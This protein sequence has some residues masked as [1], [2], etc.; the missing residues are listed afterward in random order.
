MR[1]RFVEI[2]E[3][4]VKA[5]VMIVFIVSPNIYNMNILGDILGQQNVII[6]VAKKNYPKNKAKRLI[7]KFGS[8]LLK[9][10]P[11]MYY[12]VKN[13]KIKD[14]IE[15]YFIIES[16]GLRTYEFT[17]FKNLNK[18]NN[19]HLMLLLLNSMSASSPNILAVKDDVLHSDWEAVF[20]FDKKDAIQYG[21]Q[22]IGLTYFSTPQKIEASP[23][24]SDAYFIG[25]LKGNREDLIIKVF[26]RLN[27]AQVKCD[28]DIYCYSKEQ[29]DN[30]KYKNLIHYYQQWKRYDEIQAKVMSTNC[31]I[32]ILQEG[33]ETQSVR[34]FEAVYYNKKLLTNN[35][36]IVNLPFYDE[37][38]MKYFEKAEDI[39]INWVTKKAL[40]N[41]HYAGEFSA[42]HLLE[43]IVESLKL[44]TI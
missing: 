14:D 39:D 38:Y 10:L 17:Y 31:I 44:E 30:R 28:F 19:I 13:L 20:T 24:S 36:D 15:Y 4:S 11:Y 43:Q 3:N 33:Q 6:H 23:D 22:Y 8:R 37:R 16:G 1:K 2:G 21:W 18:R 27:N 7:V 29:F 9:R 40:I 26:E 42:L 41:Y 32:E 35:P 12:D 5:G 25:G 34:Y